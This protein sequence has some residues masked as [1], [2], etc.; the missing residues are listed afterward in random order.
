MSSGII[1]P[2][3]YK[4]KRKCVL[5]KRQRP[6]REVGEYTMNDFTAEELG[7]IYEI[8]KRH[9]QELSNEK[10]F[11]LFSLYFEDK[12]LK[13]QGCSDEVWIDFFLNGAYGYVDIFENPNFSKTGKGRNIYSIHI[14]LDG[15]KELIEKLIENRY[16]S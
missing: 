4:V 12:R 16:V 14:Y 6:I 9:A 2:P 11:Y 10:I 15:V 5:V 8:V 1:I 7:W 13:E 3:D